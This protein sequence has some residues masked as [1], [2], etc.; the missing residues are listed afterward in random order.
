MS[1]EAWARLQAL[2]E[3]AL[4]LGPAER[5]AWLTRECGD[6]TELR[7]QID[8][9]L[10]ATDAG[11]RIDG[12]VGR[13]A[14]ELASSVTAGQ[15][16]GP[17]ELIEEIGRGGMGAVFLAR[18]ADGEYEAN[19]A[20][21]LIGGIRTTEHLRRFRAE[22]Q[23]LAGLDHPNIARLLDGGSTAE[24]VPWV[25]MELVEGVPLGDG[26]TPGVPPG[27]GTRPGVSAE[28]ITRYCDARGYDLG[29]RLRLFRQV[30]SA[31]Q[32]A[33][34]KAIV[35]RD[36]KPSNV[37]VT[38]ADGKPLPKVIDFGIAKIIAS[39]ED[40]A[41]HTLHRA[42]LGTL[43]YMSPEQAS[44]AQ[45]D[46]DT[47]SDIYSLG[48]LLYELTTGTLPIPV[49]RLRAAT[50]AERER[51]LRDTEPLVPSRRVATTASDD[52]LRH[53]RERS[54]RPAH[55]ARM[56]RGD[57]DNIVSMALR[58]DPAQRYPSVAQFADDIDRYLAGHPVS[59]RPGTW[60]YRA[61]LFARRH[62]AEVTA[63]AVALV[64]LIGSTALFTM[65]L[66]TAR[67][68]AESQ[69]ESAQRVSA[70]MEELFADADP[71]VSDG[72]DVTA[73]EVLDRGAARVLASLQAEPEIQA[74]LAVVMGRVYRRSGEYDA[75]GPLLDSA[76]AVGR[77]LPARENALLG[78]LL[79]ERADLA[80]ELGDYEA[81]VTLNR[82]AI[83]AYG[84]T[85]AG[86]DAD[87][88]N[89]R[90][91][92]ADALS[93]QGEVEEAETHARAAL[94]MQRRLD[95][96][97][98]GATA[99]TIVSLTDILRDRGALDEAVSL[100]REGLAM[101]RV[102][103]GDVDLEVAWALNQLASSLRSLG[104][105]EEA[106]PLI[107]EGLEIRSTIYG[108][109]HVEVGASM[110][111]LANAYVSLGR[112]D[113]ALV[114]R[115]QAAD[116]LA[117]IFP[118]NHP[119]VA[120]TAS[121][122][123]L[124]LWEVGRLEEAEAQL[125]EAIELSRTAFPEGHAQIASPLTGYG[126]ALAARGDHAGAIIALRE[127]YQIRTGSSE[128]DFNVG[129]TAIEL[130][131]AL[132]AAGHV[133]EAENYLVEAYDILRSAFGDQD[134]RVV[135]ATRV[136]REHLERRG[137]TARVAELDASQQ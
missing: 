15:R 123:G 50:P 112:Y 130:G 136:L 21:K 14:S 72:L 105:A 8:S 77:R 42:G 22:R 26:V 137:L 79:R 121:S 76:L 17:W 106:I 55:L 67:D 132:D 116:M 37:L 59:A 135:R 96:E 87:V 10:D 124:N 39:G 100:G 25:A 81:A 28:P 32:H 108:G 85:R 118:G 107:E 82:E 16:V 66:A 97:P 12:I 35:H 133:E 120:M 65:R 5:S 68:R 64:I 9:L 62:R 3:V 52:A 93:A 2:F 46:V 122:L 74:A 95:P 110:G 53:A 40:T 103:H 54:T 83:A 63:A 45:D 125:R 6:D 27:D 4:S 43:E 84:A 99:M 38:E 89:A 58:R 109:P 113:E 90:M 20:V 73:R 24:G 91:S 29:R 44:G 126:R 57:L 80:Y 134:E 1:A 131:L 51:L 101:M 7:R 13:A 94:A 19:A 49:E 70:F 115:Q 92:L 18:R 86:D 104:R 129:L 102:V 34:Q 119:Y 61:R 56:L 128:R 41:G 48:V 36:L 71:N 33:H 75:A 30:L 114:Y 88:A 69:R 60:W 127:A 78:E 47:R 23:I 111:N 117:E 31:V 98:N 11:G